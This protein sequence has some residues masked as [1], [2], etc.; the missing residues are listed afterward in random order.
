[1]FEDITLHRGLARFI[2]SKN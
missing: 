1:M 2:N